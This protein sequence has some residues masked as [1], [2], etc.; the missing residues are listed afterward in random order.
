MR[1]VD[2]AS[3]QPR[4]TLG[5]VVHKADGSV[6]D[7]GIIADSNDGSIKRSVLRRPGFK[8]TWLARI[9]RF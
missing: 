4:V 6:V 5:A 9:R 1:R 3:A 8:K 7:L 2:A